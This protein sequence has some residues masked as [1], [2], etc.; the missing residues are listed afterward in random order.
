MLPHMLRVVVSVSAAGAA[1]A[2][3]AVVR[4]IPAAHWG[5]SAAA[6]RSPVELVLWPFVLLEMGRRPA[7]W[8][9]VMLEIVAPLE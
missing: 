5:I 2:D 7:L 9:T 6:I 1:R 8:P 4:I 3:A